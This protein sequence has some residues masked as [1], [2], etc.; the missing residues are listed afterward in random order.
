MGDSQ[1]VSWI[2]CDQVRQATSLYRNS[3]TTSIASLSSTSRSIDFTT[4]PT[5]TPTPIPPPAPS[6]K[7]WIAGAVVGPIVGLAIIAGLIFWII[8]LKRKGKN[9]APAAN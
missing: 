8:Q 6:S 4:T 2:G 9:N 7:A 3:P 5:P 1:S